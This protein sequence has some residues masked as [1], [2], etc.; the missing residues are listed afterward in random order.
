MAL[1]VG[2]EVKALLVGQSTEPAQRDAINTCEH[3]LRAQ[4]PEVRWLFLSRMWRLEPTR[5]VRRGANAHAQPSIGVKSGSPLVIARRYAGR[6]PMRC[7]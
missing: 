6:S 2:V 3:A 1:F 7:R 4:F 5:L